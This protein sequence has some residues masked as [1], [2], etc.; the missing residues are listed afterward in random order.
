MKVVLVYIGTPKSSHVSFESFSPG[1]DDQ[2]RFLDSE[3]HLKLD[4]DI[5]SLFPVRKVFEYQSIPSSRGR[6]VGVV[7]KCK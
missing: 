5:T 7:Q 3:E 6:R 4:R 1:K 2:E